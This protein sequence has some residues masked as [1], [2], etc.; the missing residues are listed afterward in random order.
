MHAKVWARSC[1]DFALFWNPIIRSVP[2]DHDVHYVKSDVGFCLQRPWAE[3]QVPLKL[4]LLNSYGTIVVGQPYNMELSTQAD[5]RAT[6]IL[7]PQTVEP[8]LRNSVDLGYYLNSS[9]PVRP[10]YLVCVISFLTITYKYRTKCFEKALC[11]KSVCCMI[12]T[13]LNLPVVL[14]AHTSRILQ[15]PVLLFTWSW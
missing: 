7:P 4:E 15:L 1:S 14:H 6:F 3:T 13:G 12:G 5:A 11:S 10:P 9:S 2:C 8:D